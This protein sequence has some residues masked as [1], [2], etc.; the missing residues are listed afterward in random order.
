[1]NAEQQVD[2]GY[3]NVTRDEK[4]QRVRGVF[5]NVAS[6]YD[7]MNDAMSLGL[8]RYWKNALVERLNPKPNQHILDLAGG[9]GDVAFRLLQKQ[10]QCHVTILDTTHAMVDIAQQRCINNG[11]AAKQIDFVV[12]DG[13]AIPYPSSY[14]DH[15]CIS[16]GLRN[17]SD[18]ALVLREIY[19]VIKPG[20]S[21]YCLEF[22]TLQ[23]E[24]LGKLY[25]DYSF[26]IIPKLGQMIVG[27]KDS[28]VYLA[29]SIRRF[30]A[31]EKLKE[32]MIETGFGK[33]N[34]RN[35]HHGIV[36]LHHGIKL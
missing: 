14:F 8:H 24:F 30:P 2:F 23:Q 32:M 34:C 25:D 1:M 6:K 9:T 16:F 35:F 26:N 5:E 36:A 22:S 20:G 27:D 18:I 7:V 12:G 13:E 19:R 31:Q 29:E 28:Y 33:V 3:E 4:K 21:F 11:F 15:C 10:P 17:V